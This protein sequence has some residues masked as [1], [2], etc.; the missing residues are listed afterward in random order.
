MKLLHFGTFSEHM[1]DLANLP[2]ARLGVK[3]PEICSTARPIVSLSE[4]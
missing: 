1:G 3:D 4:T 2:A